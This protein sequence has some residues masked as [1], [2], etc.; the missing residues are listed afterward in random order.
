MNVIPHF[1]FKTEIV[2]KSI[3]DNFFKYRQRGISLFLME[4]LVDC[5]QGE[6]LFNLNNMRLRW[7]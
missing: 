2:D 7:V 3:F 6:G 1:F 5:Y 4:P